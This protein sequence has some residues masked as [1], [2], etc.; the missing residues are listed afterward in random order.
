MLIYQ[1][2]FE[3]NVTFSQVLGQLDRKFI[4]CT[5]D[6]PIESSDSVVD[7]K[8]LPA[9]FDDRSNMSTEEE[10]SSRNTLGVPVSSDSNTRDHHSSVTPNAPLATAPLL[11]VFDQ[12]AAHERVRLE[13]LLSDNYRPTDAS[14]GRRKLLSRP[15]SPPLKVH[16][17]QPELRVMKHFQDTIQTYGFVFK[18]VSSL[19]KKNH[20]YVR[21]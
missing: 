18:I 12:H 5:L 17:S 16:F 2:I 11:V 19:Y 21:R 14:D 15:V 4:V 10:C 7:Q 13:T 20:L 1:S 8:N 6:Y 9:S 3:T